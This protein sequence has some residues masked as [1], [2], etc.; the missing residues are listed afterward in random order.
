[1][2]PAGW[3]NSMTGLPMGA[4]WPQ[5]QHGPVRPQPAVA[6]AERKTA[7]PPLAVQQALAMEGFNADFGS[8]GIQAHEVRT[9]TA[10]NIG[11]VQKR[12]GGSAGILGAGPAP[13]RP[14]GLMEVKINEEMVSQFLHSQREEEGGQQQQQHAGGDETPE[15]TPP[16][17]RETTPVPSD[18]EEGEEETGMRVVDRSGGS[19]LVPH[20]PQIQMKLFQRLQSKVA[21]GQLT[22]DSNAALPEAV[23]PVNDNKPENDNKEGDSEDDEDKDVIVNVLK[24]LESVKSCPE[25]RSPVHTPLTPTSLPKELTKMLSAISSVKPASSNV[26]SPHGEKPPSPPRPP[27]DAPIPLPPARKGRPDP[28]RERQAQREE[29][30]R[31]ERERDQRILDLDLG[32]MFGDLE[33][34]PL[35]PSPQQT[36]QEKFLSDS[37]GL[38]FKPHIYHVAKEIE[39]GLNSHP[40][41]EWMLRAVVVPKPDYSHLRHHCSPAQ[42]ELDPRLR[43]YS[44]R[45]SM[46]RLKELPLPPPGPPTPK[47][48]PR[49]KGRLDPRRQQ[50]QPPAPPPE[51][52]RSSSEDGEGNFVYNP[53][54]ELNRAKRAAGQQLSGQAEAYSSDQGEQQQ[55]LESPAYTEEE[56]WAEEHRNGGFHQNQQQFYQPQHAPFSPG[57]PAQL[58]DLGFGV[59]NQQFPPFPN[60]GTGFNQHNFLMQQQQQFQSN[61]QGQMMRGFGWNQG[62]APSR[63]QQFGRGSFRSRGARPPFHLNRGGGGRGEQGDFAA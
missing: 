39:A 36:D 60:D 30:E 17:S 29:E 1:M 11:P 54:K 3:D 4:G 21:A 27:A 62:G 24:R 46:A 63:Q 59:A 49:L 19:P 61:I 20:M 7:E 23:V 57:G 10:F 40:P 58:M 56:A 8:G 51:E 15:V 14:A 22:E 9:R 44:A 12:G 18:G 43:R 35:A 33:L 5:Q 38:P 32:S 50:A 34:P 45:S 53:A 55:Q 16:V 26:L 48:D 2:Q 25:E 28:R 42:L 41:M 6:W 13:P 31:L 37:L 47:V 52:R